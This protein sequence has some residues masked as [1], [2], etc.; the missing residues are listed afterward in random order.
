MTALDA[1]TEWLRAHRAEG[2]DQRTKNIAAMLGMVG[3]RSAPGLTALTK[4]VANT[5]SVVLSLSRV[6][7]AQA[8]ML[9]G[10]ADEN[11]ALRARVEKLEAAPPR[12]GPGPFD[13]GPF[14]GLG[15]L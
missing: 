15:G 3:E 6:S 7:T 8:N 5:V 10:L 4:A 12:P 1:I 14:G 13:G 11:A 9:R 2:A